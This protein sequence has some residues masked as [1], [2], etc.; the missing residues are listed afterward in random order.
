MHFPRT[1]LK[2]MAKLIP[3]LLSD[4]FIRDNWVRELSVIVEVIFN[5]NRSKE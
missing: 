2:T 1:P 3:T 5:K 4:T